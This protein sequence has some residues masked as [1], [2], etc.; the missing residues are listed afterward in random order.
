MPSPFFPIT[1]WFLTG[2]EEIGQQ[3]ILQITTNWQNKA[4]KWW[5]SFADVKPYHKL[6][7][8]SKKNIPSNI[9]G[10]SN[11]SDA[12]QSS[13]NIT[14]QT[15]FGQQMRSGDLPVY[16]ALMHSQYKWENYHCLIRNLL[17]LSFKW[18]TFCSWCYFIRIHPISQK[19]NSCVTDLRTDWRT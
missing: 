11:L 8:C 14:S 9:K 18:H 7:K 15:K 10:L 12:R 17:E 13:S 16:F 2:Y 4:L 5:D 19:F 3:K 1:R 6:T